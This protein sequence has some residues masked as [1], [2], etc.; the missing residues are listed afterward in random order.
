MLDFLDFLLVTVGHVISFVQL[1]IDEY[2]HI[3]L[4]RRAAVLG[5]GCW[6]WVLGA[7]PEQQRD[8]CLLG[9][10]G[11]GW[12]CHLKNKEFSTNKDKVQKPNIVS[13]RTIY[14]INNITLLCRFVCD[15]RGKSYLNKH[16]NEKRYFEIHI[17]P[18]LKLINPIYCDNTE[19]ERRD[20]VTCQLKSVRDCRYWDMSGVSQHHIQPPTLRITRADNG[21]L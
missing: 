12:D 17:L 8:S 20:S 13:F 7:D 14:F 3:I 11:D 18:R 16:F 1:D 21:S 19:F 4:E 2:L 5:A 10:E 6:C 9:A 15:N